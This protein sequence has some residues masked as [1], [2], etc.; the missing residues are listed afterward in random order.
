LEQDSAKSLLDVIPGKAL[1]DLNRAGSALLEIVTAPVLKSSTEAVS[2]VER[3]QSSLLHVGV[4]DGIMAEGSLR[5]DVNVSVH[6]PKNPDSHRSNRVEIKNL[7]SIRSLKRSIDFEF[8]RH[9][10]ALETQS[11]VP[12]ET[13][14]F[15]SAQGRT[16]RLRSKEDQHDYRFM[17]DPDLPW[18]VVSEEMI[19]RVKGS[20][21]ELPDAMEKRLQ[22]EL[23]LS[24]YEAQVVSADPAIASFYT[25]MLTKLNV[26]LAKLAWNWLMNEFVGR[27]KEVDLKVS[28]ARV[29]A[30]QLASIVDIVSRG[31]VSSKIGKSILSL[32]LDGDPRD[33]LKI[34][35]QN[36]WTANSDGD[37]V[38]STCH[39]VMRE[40]DREIHASDQKLLNY[41]VGQVMKKLKGRVNPSLVKEAMIKLMKSVP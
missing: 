13:R 11:N 28:D 36:Q 12:K 19:E 37:L 21:P 39:Q 16:V 40:F 27:L 10:A 26:S 34:A 18:L 31:I 5:V 2:F 23:G 14:Y 3:L 4:C 24:P 20:L 7:N 8:S 38:I 33:A 1:V 35:E 29:S 32:M 15:D 25:A 17:P 22:A 6:D 41:L 9:V 30:E